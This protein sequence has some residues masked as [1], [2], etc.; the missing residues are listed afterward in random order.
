MG[1]VGFEVIRWGFRNG[2][3]NGGFRNGV[4]YRFLVPGSEPVSGGNGGR[5][6]VLIGLGGGGVRDLIEM[7]DEFFSCA[8]VLL[9]GD[10]AE[11]AVDCFG[12]GLELCGDFFGGE[13]LG[14]GVE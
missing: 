1:R 5:G 7:V 11:I 9:L 8:E 2:F 3:R 14:G 4:G 12:G 6:L 10:V 13:I